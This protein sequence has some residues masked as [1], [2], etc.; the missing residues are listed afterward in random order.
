MTKAKEK[1]MK[2]NALRHS[3]NLKNYK[4]LDENYN[5]LKSDPNLRYDKSPEKVMV[6][7]NKLSTVTYT[8]RIK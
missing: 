8:P 7:R 1:V 2:D 3:L 5:N 4:T 6:K